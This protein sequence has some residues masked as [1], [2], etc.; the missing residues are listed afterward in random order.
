MKNSE[1][2]VISVFPEKKIPLKKKGTLK[3][4]T[5]SRTKTVSHR[6]SNSKNVLESPNSIFPQNYGQPIMVTQKPQNIIIINQQFPTITS[7]LTFGLSPVKMTCPYCLNQIE[8]L[9]EKRCSCLTCLFY[10]MIV[11]LCAIPL[12]I[13]TGICN[14]GGVTVAPMCDCDCNC[15]CD[16]IHLCPNCGKMIGEYDSCQNRC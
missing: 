9:V 10:L 3:K 16:G 13:C 11:L 12:L 8:S 14:S 1:A 7:P 15:C 2:N 4:P 6:S 5:L